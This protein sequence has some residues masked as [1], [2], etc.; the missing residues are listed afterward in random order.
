MRIITPRFAGL[1]V[2]FLIVACGEPGP[3]PTPTATPT[4]GDK[5]AV[6]DGKSM[7]STYAKR[8]DYLLRNLANWCSLSEERIA[9]MAL[10]SRDSL[11]DTYGIEVEILDV[12]EEVNSTTAGLQ[13]GFVRCE[14]VMALYVV[15]KGQ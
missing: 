15:L 12:L 1:F 5:V 4:W 13:S 8:V 6:I 9:D 14:E 2:V 10:V 11:L 3:T 7:D